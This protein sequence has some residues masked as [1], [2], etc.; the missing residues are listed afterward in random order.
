[1]M[2]EGQAKHNISKNGGEFNLDN[3]EV[4]QQHTFLEYVF[5]GCEIDLSIAIDFTM[6]NGEPR[7]ASSLHYFDPQKN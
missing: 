3:M 5:G 2:K 4:K 1:M 7:D 6:S